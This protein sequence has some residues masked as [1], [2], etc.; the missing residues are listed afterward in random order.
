MEGHQNPPGAS[1]PEVMTAI[2]FLAMFGGAALGEGTSCVM[3]GCCVVVVEVVVVV[4]VV[5][6]FKTLSSKMYERDEKAGMAETTGHTCDSVLLYIT[7]AGAD[8]AASFVWESNTRPRPTQGF[9]RKAPHTREGRGA[10]ATDA[11]R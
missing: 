4:V 8:A 5:K 11:V 2:F 6:S 10:R 7:A 9:L 1:P 3:V